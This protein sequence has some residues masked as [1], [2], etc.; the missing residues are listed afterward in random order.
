MDTIPYDIV[1]KIMNETGY[2]SMLMFILTNKHNYIWFKP[3]FENKYSTECKKPFTKWLN[4]TLDI[5]KKQ[6][7][8]YKTNALLFNEFMDMIYLHYKVVMKR[9][10]MIRNH[11]LWRASEYHHKLVFEENINISE[12]DMIEDTRK[13]VNKMFKKND[14]ERYPSFIQTRI[15]A[16]L[17]H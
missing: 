13:R 1:Y 12:Y 2:M 4:I 6:P 10:P 11:I 7:T 9:E 5:I 16:Y 15:R 17:K 8:E 14:L 3:Y